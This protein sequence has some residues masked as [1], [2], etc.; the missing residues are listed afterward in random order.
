M[1]NPNPD[2]YA[3][4]KGLTLKAPSRTGYLF[5]GWYLDAHYREKIT[6]VAIGTRGELTLY[7]KWT[8]ISYTLSFSANGGSGSASR[9][10]LSYGMDTVLPDSGFRR[11]GYTLTGWNTAKDGTGDAYLPGET[12]RDLKETNKASLT[13]YAQWSPITYRLL[14]DPNDGITEAS[15]Q[16]LTYNEGWVLPTQAGDREGYHISGWNTRSNGKGRTY[17][18]GKPVKNLADQGD[19]QVTLYGKWTVNRYQVLF[20]GNGATA[21]DRTQTMTYGKTAALTANVDI[22]EI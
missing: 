5:G 7:P 17:T 11:R 19:A 20:H 6:S 16:E 12:V 3:S 22:S 14:L 1:E 9:R 13:L 4:P 2:S 10:R 8:A 15:T 18:P 21:R